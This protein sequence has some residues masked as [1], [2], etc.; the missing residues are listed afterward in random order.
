MTYGET[1]D[2]MLDHAIEADDVSQLLNAGLMLV[3]YIV[4]EHAESPDLAGLASVNYLS[5]ASGLTDQHGTAH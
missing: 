3:A 2:E 4:R 5:R 1:M